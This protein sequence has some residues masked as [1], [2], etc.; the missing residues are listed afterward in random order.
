MKGQTMAILNLFQY[1]KDQIPYSAGQVIFSEQ[2]TGE[3]MYVVIDGE[4][5]VS[6]HGQSIETIGPGGLLGE[7]AIIDHKTRSATATAK[8]DCKL[9]AIDQQRFLFMI[10]E[11]PF[12]GLE[13]MKVMADRLRRARAEVAADSSTT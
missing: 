13:V 7:L 12:F 4:V 11:T 9:V 10:E 8:T 5:E 6:Y 3:V 2:D 1:V